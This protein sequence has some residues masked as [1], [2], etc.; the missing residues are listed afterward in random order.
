MS[1]KNKAVIHHPIKSV[2]INEQLKR[3]HVDVSKRD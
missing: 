2:C 3:S 1:N